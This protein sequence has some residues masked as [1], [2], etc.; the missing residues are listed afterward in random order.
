MLHKTR[1]CF[2]IAYY[3]GA[4]VVLYAGLQVWKGR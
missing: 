2:R 4:L 1:T 3:S